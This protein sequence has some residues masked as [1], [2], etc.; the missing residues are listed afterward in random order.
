[1]EELV[2]LVGLVI[3]EQMERLLIQEPP[4]PKGKPEPKERLELLVQPD[5]LEN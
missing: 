4:E 1:M 2:L 5:L 3:L